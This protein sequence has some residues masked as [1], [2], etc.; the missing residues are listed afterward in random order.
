M[1]IYAKKNN[2]GKP[3][4][5]WVV[6]IRREGKII[7]KHT[8]DL[9]E[10]RQIEAHLRAGIYVSPTAIERPKVFTLGDLL[11]GSRAIYRGTKDERQ[12]MQR[13]EVALGLLGL[14]VDIRTIRTAQ[15]DKLVETFRRERCL[16][17]KTINRYLY[18]VSAAFK[19]AEQRE[20]IDRAPKIPRQKESIGRIA[21]LPDDMEAPFI[22]WLEA[23]GYQ[24]V[25]FV[26]QALIKTGFRITEL[27][28]IEADAISKDGWVRLHDG[29]T[30][31]NQGR[32]V[33]VGPEMA[34]S[35]LHW[36]A[37]GFPFYHR[38]LDAMRRASDALGIEPGIT[39]HVL[40]HTTA[41]RLNSANVPT[42][43]IAKLLGHKSLVTTLKYAHVEE[44]ALME[45]ATHLGVTAG[46]VGVPSAG[47]KSY[48]KV[49][50][51]ASVVPLRNHLRL[52]EKPPEAEQGSQICSPLR[53]HSATRP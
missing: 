22:G 29:E 9:K 5:T 34:L 31:N 13:L 38:T 17:N 2:E 32:S 7:R 28:G 23:N 53:N 18:A 11:E 51:E 46:A 12:S 52:I 14:S 36:Q 10:A 37:F 27:M 16:D 8:K 20:L 35:L 6:E 30:K 25:A 40:R 43:T 50:P 49:A 47:S 21:F 48:S 45:A 26:T 19:W 42:A 1:S 39:P 4:G 33:Y 41:T 44:K 24:D 15:L 3:T